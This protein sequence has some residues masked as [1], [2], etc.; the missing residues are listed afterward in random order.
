MV[1]CQVC[2]NEINDAQFCRHCGSK[3][4]SDESSKNVEKKF[5]PNCGSEMNINADFC[6][7]CGTSLNAP[8]NNPAKSISNSNKSPTSA[9][10]LS[11]LIIGLG[12]IYLGLTKKGITLFILAIISGILTFLLIGWIFLII[13]WIYGM[14]DAY[15]SGEKILRG[16]V[17]EDSLF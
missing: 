7:E 9:L 6:Q 5:C 10:V 2:G 15:T 8:Q 1:K 12:Q 4:N 3:I 13:L 16:E 17:V 14:Y 11:L